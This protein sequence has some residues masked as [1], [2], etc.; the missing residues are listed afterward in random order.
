MVRS[1]CIF[2]FQELIRCS[3]DLADYGRHIF[4]VIPVCHDRN[5][6]IAFGAINDSGFAEIGFIVRAT[7]AEFM[8]HFTFAW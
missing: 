4:Q 8:C 6:I 3:G 5:Q 7:F 1:I 2:G